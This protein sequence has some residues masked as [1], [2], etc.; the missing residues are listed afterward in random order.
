[1]HKITNVTA[2]NRHHHH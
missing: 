1:M 2:H